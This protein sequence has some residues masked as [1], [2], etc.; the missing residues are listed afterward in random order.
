MKKI[1]IS[2]LFI[3]VIVFQSCKNDKTSEHNIQ[4]ATAVASSECYQAIYKADTLDLVIHTLENSAI[5]GELT[6][7][8]YGSPE[9]TGKIKGKFSGD[10]L[11]ADYTFTAVNDPKTTYK[12][13]LA[14]LRRDSLLVLGNGQIETTMG[15]SYFVKGLPIDF[16]R[17]K[18]KFATT[19]CQPN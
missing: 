16:D 13:P 4:S 17:V 7:K 8:V 14:L 11:F 10:T 5:T 15:K 1:L 12:N 3:A 2:G 9:K 18:Y 6:M 19:D